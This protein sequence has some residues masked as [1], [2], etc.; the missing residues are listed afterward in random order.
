MSILPLFPLK[1]DGIVV[2]KTVI[3]ID[4]AEFLFKDKAFQDERD[5]VFTEATADKSLDEA[6]PKF[7][8][9]RSAL[10]QVMASDLTVQTNTSSTAASSLK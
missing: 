2:L 9:M 7:E 8:L 4:P 6:F 5:S 3:V 1:H 10:G